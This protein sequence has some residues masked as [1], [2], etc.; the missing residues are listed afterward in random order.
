[1]VLTEES[2]VKVYISADIEGVAGITAP[3]EANPDHKDVRYFQDQM[4]LEVKAA[5]E[6]AIAAGAK[7]ILVKDAHWTG[8]NINPRQLPDCVR[9][10]RGWSG[11]PF[12]MMAEIDAS[13]A[14]ALYIGYHARAGSAGN[15]LA[16]TMRGAMVHEMRVNERP[17]SEFLINTY[18]A[19][20]VGVPVCFLAGDESLCQEVKAYDERI[21]TVSTFKG[22]GNATVSLHPDL[23]IRQIRLGVEEALRR[24]QKP[25]LRPLPQRFSIEIDYVK[26]RD[27]YGR[28]FYPGA[29]LKGDGTVRFE[30]AQ[31]LDCLTMIQF[32][33]K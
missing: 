9:M 8:R 26:P 16:H 6:G 13:F 4:T 33:I 10:V 18:T 5:C 23:A 24:D 19:A 15:P 7:E 28:S 2:P 30:S 27:A 17:A 14:S 20:S 1:L 3:E 21:R 31:W 12:S 29:K 32:C 11:H 25:L 22:I